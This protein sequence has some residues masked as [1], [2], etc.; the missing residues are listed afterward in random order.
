[1]C[2]QRHMNS[3]LVAGVIVVLV[4]LVAMCSQ[5]IPKAIKIEQKR[6][7]DTDMLGEARRIEVMDRQ[8]ES[9]VERD[10]RE[11]VAAEKK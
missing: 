9:Q 4:T 3:W 11:M 7:I 1:M 10:Y 6:Q 8:I 2:T 5:E